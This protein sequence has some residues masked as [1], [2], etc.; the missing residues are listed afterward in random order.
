MSCVLSQKTISSLNYCLQNI[1]L[2]AFSF[3]ILGFQQLNRGKMKAVEALTL[4]SL[5]L[6]RDNWSISNKINSNLIVRQSP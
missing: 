6:N 4:V 1:R 2:L 3:E 5:L